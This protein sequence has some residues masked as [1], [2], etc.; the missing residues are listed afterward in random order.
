MVNKG[1]FSIILRLLSHKLIIITFKHCE[2][3]SAKLFI[4]SGSTPNKGK[5]ETQ[6]V[7]IYEHE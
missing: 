3:V 7:Q 5:D 4:K 6:S 2:V 1:L